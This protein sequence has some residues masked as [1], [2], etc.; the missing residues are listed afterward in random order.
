MGREG[1]GLRDGKGRERQAGGE[2]KGWKTL[3]ICSP[4]KF[5]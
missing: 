2:E 4:G 3:W 1:K 5:S